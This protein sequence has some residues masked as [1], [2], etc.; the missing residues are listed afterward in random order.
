MEKDYLKEL[1]DFYA[2]LSKEQKDCVERFAALSDDEK[3]CVRWHYVE[4]ES[5]RQRRPELHLIEKLRHLHSDYALF[6]YYQLKQAPPDKETPLH[7][8]LIRLIATSNKEKLGKLES[9]LAD[10][11]IWQRK[12]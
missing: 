10:I 12:K 6:V 11:E 3:K 7:N 9:L 5:I 1:Q 8:Q 2:A 4:A